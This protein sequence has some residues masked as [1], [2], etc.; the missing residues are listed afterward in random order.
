MTI[1]PRSAAELREW[2]ARIDGLR[3]SG[4]LRLRQR[5]DDLLLAGRLHERYDQFYPWRTRFGADMA[6][7]LNRG[8][9]V[10]AYGNVFEGIDVDTTPSITPDRALQV[11]ADRAGVEIGQYARTGDSAAR[12]G[13]AI[14]LSPC[15]ARPCLRP[16]RPPR[17][18]VD[19][20]D[21]SIAFDFSDLRTQGQSAVG[22]G[23]G[24]LG[25]TKKVSVSPS[26][27]QFVTTDRLRPPAINTYD[28]RGNYQRTIDYLNEVIQLFAK[29]SGDPT[30]TT[31]GP[32]APTVDAHTYA[33][34]TYDYYFKRFGRRGLDNHDLPIVSLVHPARR[35]DIFN[36]S[37]PD[38]FY[39]NAFY[40][41]G[42]VMV[43]GE[44]L[45]PGFTLCG[46]RSDYLAGALDIVAHELTHGV[47][48]SRPGS[49][50]ATSPG[51][52]NEAFSDIMGIAWS[53]S[54]SQP[55]SGN[56]RGRLP[57][58]RRRDL[59]RAASARRPNPRRIRPSRSLFAAFHGPRGQRRRPHQL[60]HRQPRLLPG[61]RRRHQPDVGT[62]R[63]RASAPATASRSRRCSTGHSHRCCRRTPRSRSRARQR[64]SRPATLRREQRRRARRHASLD[65]G[66]CQLSFTPQRL[67]LP[68]LLS[69]AIVCAV[70][71]PSQAQSWPER[72]H[73]SVNGAYQATTNDFSDR[74]EF[75]RNLETGSTDVDYPLKGGFVF[76][77]GAGFRLWKNLG[78]GVSVSYFTRDD[79]ASTTSSVPHP[80]FFQ[81]PREVIGDATGVKRS[82]TA[83]H[84]QAMYLGE[85]GGTAAPRD[86]RRSVLLQC[87]TGPGH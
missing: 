69:V 21:G 46:H 3:R 30:P 83:V 73:V 56:L 45:P 64:S 47:T 9:L 29:R 65:S 19:A 52:L 44:G 2:G 82:E 14:E 85:H 77:A 18:F 79:V 17:D 7:Q 63:S 20:R 68:V 80:L 48:D 50:T 81:Q 49:S 37:I 66:R 86:F 6:Q 15:V 75:Q 59:V 12:R 72:V 51:A 74:F 55:G 1:R 39:I 60:G 5:R 62:S 84:V 54:S 16:S 43:Y 27:G 61:D 71:T 41:G 35:Q 32:T 4:D 26:G 23:Q 24:V 70:T 33:G 10:S 31:P 13:R 76:D 8:Q 11:V 34:W 28:M 53:S 22:S 36:L 42:G 67:T 38:D 87:R 25:D 58:R 40:A 78:A 57:D